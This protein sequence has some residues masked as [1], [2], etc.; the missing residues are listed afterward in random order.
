MSQFRIDDQTLVSVSPGVLILSWYPPGLADD[1]GEPAEDLVPTVLDTAY[2]HNLKVKRHQ[3]DI[4]TLCFIYFKKQA[5]HKTWRNS[6][7]VP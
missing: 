4:R 1:N 3:K 7:T 5:K 2:R 6:S